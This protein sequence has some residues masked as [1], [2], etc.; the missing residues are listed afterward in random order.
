MD[1]KNYCQSESILI[2]R[3]WAL[4]ATDDK[5]AACTYNKHY[6]GVDANIVIVLS[7][8]E[9]N[10][11]FV[12]CFNLSMTY[13]CVRNSV[14]TQFL[15]VLSF[16]LCS[17]WCGN[18]FRSSLLS[19]VLDPGWPPLQSLHTPCG[20]GNVTSIDDLP[21]QFLHMDP[22]GTPTADR[23]NYPDWP[24]RTQRLITIT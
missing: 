17:H 10:T 9:F 20:A 1:D 14:H 7:V 19:R 22:P 24:S 21:S 12:W 16:A 18:R 13:E 8:N 23:A 15:L 2:Q 3:A 5:T 11:L 6:I 4:K